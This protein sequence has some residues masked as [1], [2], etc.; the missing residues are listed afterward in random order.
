VLYNAGPCFPFYLRH[1]ELCLSERERE[2]RS[3]HEFQLSN[4]AHSICSLHYCS[5]IGWG[6][7]RWVSCNSQATTTSSCILAACAAMCSV[8]HVFLMSD[9]GPHHRLAS[10]LTKVDFTATWPVQ[11]LFLMSCY[12]LNITAGKGKVVSVF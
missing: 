9:T 4:G 5:W 2:T 6:A 12:C 7:G 8:L 10:I 3:V 1:F 11:K